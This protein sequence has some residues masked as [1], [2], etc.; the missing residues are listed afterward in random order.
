[1]DPIPIPTS[2]ELD[3]T[4]LWF[5]LGPFLVAL[6]V[7]WFK[8]RFP[9]HWKGLGPM[10]RV[11]LPVVLSGVWGGLYFLYSA[12]ATGAD[13][14]GALNTFF[15]ALFAIVLQNLRAQWQK[16]NLTKSE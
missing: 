7:H 4:Y 9:A 5:G 14:R 3:A 6:V 2:G 16:R 13:W 1:M 15:A 12:L 8:R 11:G 10:G